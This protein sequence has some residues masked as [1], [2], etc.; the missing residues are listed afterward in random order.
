[1]NH[2]LLI[3]AIV[4][5]PVLTL[6]IY[7]GIVFYNQWV[8]ARK[9]RMNVEEFYI[10]CK[11]PA[12]LNLKI[13]EIQVNDYPVFTKNDSSELIIELVIKGHGYLIRRHINNLFYELK[14]IRKTN[15][16]KK[17]SDNDNDLEKWQN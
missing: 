12:Y 8:I 2:N 7:I 5:M 17:I 1:M 14:S 3:S 16:I 15:A 13:N 9:I 6:L 11:S 10:L 4:L